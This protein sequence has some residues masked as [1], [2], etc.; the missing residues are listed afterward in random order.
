[1]K[2]NKY[3]KFFGWL[4]AATM[5]LTTSCKD[6]LFEGTNELSDEVT[7]SFTLTPEAAATVAMRGDNN[8]GHVTYPDKDKGEYAH[9][10]D[11]SKADV[12]IYAVYD[13][14]GN[15][16]E[17][18]SG[19]T[20]PDLAK[21]GFDHGDG[22]T[23]MKIDHFPVVV[24][25]ALKRGAKYRVAFWAQSSETKAYNTSDLRKV[26]VI[27][28]ELDNSTSEQEEEVE[29]TPKSATGDKSENTSHQTT[30]PNNDESR[31]AFC[32][33]VPI[34]ISSDA[35]KNTIQQNVYLYRPLA[36]INVGT[37]GFDYEAVTRNALKKY[38]Y[39][40]IRVNR[41]ARYLDLWADKTYLSTTRAESFTGEETPEA[42]AVVDYGYAPI[43]AY[44]NFKDD[45][46][47]DPNVPE[48]PSYT[49][50]DW[51]YVDGN[52]IH[53]DSK[54]RAYY[55]SEEFL[56][57]KL[58]KDIRDD[59]GNLDV[60]KLTEGYASDK[61]PEGGDGY[62][63]YANMYANNEYRSK[64]GKK[65]DLKSETFK[66]LSMCYVLTAST[67]DT[68]TTF[69][70]VKVWLATDKDGSDSIKIVDLNHV[71]AQRNWRTNIVGNLL[72]E[73]NT[74]SVTLDKDF[75][76]EYNGW[77]NDGKWEY[78]TGPIADGVYYDAMN[79]EIQISNANGLIW[80]Q[81]MVNGT[82]TIREA[83]EWDT[84]VGKWYVYNGDKQTK[85][86]Y[87]GI[88][89]PEDENLKKRI[90]TATHMKK[91]PDGNRFHFCGEHGEK[92]DSAAKVKLMADIDLSSVEW[93]PIGF[94]GRILE[95]VNIQFNEA[96]ATNRGF[97]GIFDG[98][99][100]TISNLTTKRFGA[101]VSMPMGQERT[102]TN[103]TSHNPNNA[104]NSKYDG[105]YRYVDNPQWFGRGLFGEIGGHAKIKNVRL[106]NVD[107]YGCHGVGGVVGIAYG[108]NI[109]ITNCVVDGGSL[110]VTPMYRGDNKDG[111][112]DKDRTFARGVYLGGIVGYFNTTGRVDRCEVK[113]L[114]MRGY[115][116]VGGLI[117]SVDLGNGQ[118]TG[119]G[120]VNHAT[121]AGTKNSKSNPTSISNNI[122][123]NTVI[124][125]SQ[126][127]AFGLRYGRNYGD[128]K[129]TAPDKPNP[130]TTADYATGFG[131]DT[132][133][134][135]LYANTFVGGDD[136]DYVDKGKTNENGSPKCSNN[137]KS[138][139]TLARFTETVD[140]NKCIRNSEMDA[141]PLEHMPILSS[142]FT[143]KVNLKANYY[144]KPSAQTIMKTREFQ[145]E[146]KSSTNNVKDNYRSKK[147]YFPM[148]IPGKVEVEWGKDAGN[149]GLYV[150]SVELDGK[151]GLGGRS[152]I[153]P[154]NVT[155]KNDCA[156]FVTARDHK[157][158][159]EGWKDAADKPST[160][161]KET[162]ISNVVVRGEPYAY[163][164]I[165]LSPN[166][167]MSKIT[168][169]TVAIYDVYRTI[170]MSDQKGNKS[171]T[172]WKEWPYDAP[173]ATDVEIEVNDCNLRGYT[174]LGKGWESITFNHTTFEEGSYIAKIYTT[175]DKK[176]EAY[177]YKADAPATFKHCY[178]KAPY[179]IDFNGNELKFAPSDTD[180]TKPCYATA[181]SP[182]NV[183]ISHEFKPIGENVNKLTMIRIISN[184]QGDPIVIYYYDGQST[185]YGYDY[186]SNGFNGKKYNIN[187]NEIKAN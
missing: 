121:V 155:G 113:N 54:D 69:Y 32:R 108:D 143:D 14:E 35:T 114:F 2:H 38:T 182:K 87:Y 159:W 61:F 135:D 152:L 17:G 107:V 105:S 48:K 101:E 53:P 31:D 3:I 128:N 102:S 89:E 139:V 44:V 76:G 47:E 103:N 62:L 10:S 98:N 92:N 8:S 133:A 148:D 80:F 140:E 142:W 183:K 172:Q 84:Y 86:Q 132:A 97:Y 15:L 163:T 90:L 27:Y 6:S 130:R 120:D 173:I 127:S 5:L 141:A 118:G 145:V 110:I 109:E 169:N 174:N 185:G 71:P 144:G 138:N 184:A 122:I 13:D 50:W 42:F 166:E 51:D 36:Q 39:S 12:L 25:I 181:T 186:D 116:R 1:M 162:T 67:E 21:K 136:V 60:N 131:W 178:F 176:R 156:L 28:S 119:E 23:I 41:A 157:E 11:G 20:D 7:V 104:N 153:T 160:Y 134:Y 77:A 154:E 137:I 85:F 82:M 4:T 75:A 56:K 19:G 34:E 83:A 112:N 149:V 72:S 33:I 164:G 74:F 124:I 45:A 24:N 187:G 57:V 106:L 70:N 46:L 18:Y 68:K 165:L 167:N 9:I 100:H 180:D 150:E 26:E 88:T 59:E 29:E 147:M 179:I 58:Y 111:D 158:F 126:F 37:N 96:D 170:A 115:R 129:T 49:I 95:T 161:K 65:D 175:A 16:L 123:S 99:N 79:D 43:P 73:D 146:F 40:K 81:R 55:G 52:F 64:N 91:W 63:D 78:L 22:Q 30:T 125:A 117:G 93:I 66:Y 177:T 151:E 171:E 94:D 168:L